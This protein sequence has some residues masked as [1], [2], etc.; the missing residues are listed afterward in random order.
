MLIGGRI[1]LGGTTP[2]RWALVLVVALLAVPSAFA[3]KV[4]DSFIGDEG[5]PA[6]G[7]GAD[8]GEFNVPRDVA[9]NSS[10]AGGVVAGTTY[11]VDSVNHRIQRHGPDG[12]FVSLWGKDVVEPGEENDSG[13]GFE[14]CDTTAGSPNTAEDCQA[15]EAGSLGG[16]LSLP[17]GIAV[18]QDTGA[19]YVTDRDNN[20]VQQYTATGAFVRA[21]GWDVVA[22]G[23]P[24]DPGS[25]STFQICQSAAAADCKAGVA[26]GGVGQIGPNTGLNT[27]RVEVTRDGT[28]ASG[29]VLVADGGN[30]NSPNRR[31]LKF[32]LDGTVAALPAIGSSAQ[33]GSRQ[34]NHIAVDGNTLY[35]ADGTDARVER[36]DLSTGSSLGPVPALPGGAPAGLEIDPVT[37]RLL[38]V[39]NP[40]QAGA[41]TVIYEI[42][43]AETGAPEIVDVHLTGSGDQAVNGLGVAHFGSTDRL[44]VSSNADPIGHRVLVLD[45]DGAGPIG[46]DILGPAEIGGHDAVLSGLVSPNG[47]TGFDTSYDFEY[48]KDGVSWVT[49]PGDP[50]TAP[51]GPGPELVSKLVDGLEANTFYRVR[52]LARREFAKDLELLSPELTFLT[53]KLPPTVAALAANRITDTEAQ[54]RARLNPE[55]SPTQWHFQYVDDMEYAESGWAN[56][57]SEPVPA[58]QAVGTTARNVAADVDGLQPDTIYHYRLVATNGQ[59]VDPVGAPGDLVVEGAERTFT[60]WAAVAAPEGRSYEMVTSPDKPS[61]RGGEGAPAFGIPD[62]FPI[63]GLPSSDG[64]RILWSA[65]LGTVATA[66]GGTAFPHSQPFEVFERLADRWDPEAVF[67]LPALDAGVDAV[68]TMDAS[69]ADLLTQTWRVESTQFPSGSSHATRILGDDGGYLGSGWYD[70]LAEIPIPKLEGEWLTG[71]DEAVVGENRSFMVRFASGNTYRGLL[72]D[73][74][75]SGVGYPNEVQSI[76][77]SGASGGSFRLTFDGQTTGTIALDASAM[78]VEGALEALSNLDPPDV[79]VT[80]GDDQPWLVIFEGSKRRVDVPEITA[81]ATGLVGPPERAVVVVTRRNGWPAAPADAPTQTT[82]VAPYVMGPPDW[83]PLDLVSECTAGTE[84]PMRDPEGTSLLSSFDPG[85]LADDTIGGQPCVE[86]EVVSRRGAAGGDGDR[87][88]V[89]AASGDGRRIFFSAPDQ[90]SAVIANNLGGSQLGMPDSNGSKRCAVLSGTDLDAGSDFVEHVGEQTECPPQV[91]VR[92]YDSQGEPTVRWLSR[93][94]I[95]DQNAD[96]LFRGAYFEGA[97]ADGRYVFFRTA[98]PLVGDDP[99]AGSD[100]VSGTAQEHSWDLYRYELPESLDDD[101]AGPAAGGLTRI[102]GG[103]SGGADPNTNSKGSAL[104]HVSQDGQRVYFVTRAP[105]GGGDADNSLP[106]DGATSPGGSVSQDSTRN[107][108]LYDADSDSYKFI[109][110]LPYADG[111]VEACASVNGLSAYLRNSIGALREVSCVRGTS[112]GDAVVFESRARLTVDDTDDASDVYLYDADID[113][114][115]RLSAPPEQEEPYPCAVLV[116]PGTH[117]TVPDPDVACN[118]DLGLHPAQWGADIGVG[119]LAG[120]SRL[121]LAEDS[122][123]GLRAVYFESRLGLLPADVNDGYFDTYEWRAGRLSLVSPGV[124]D[125]HAFYSGNGRDGDDVFFQTTQRISPWEVDAVDGDVYDARVGGGLPDPPPPP[126]VCD[127]LGGGCQGAGGGVSEPVSQPTLGTGGGD[128]EPGDRAVLSVAV[129]ARSRRAAARRRMLALTVRSNVAGRVTARARARV[130]TRRRAR[131]RLRQVAA[132]SGRVSGGGT[133]A[134]V[135]L[136]LNA[137]A[138]RQLR[139][140][141]RLTLSIVISMPGARPETID[142]ALSGRGRR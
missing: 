28:P 141:G 42:E 1:Q 112:S 126:A 67:S 69:S 111:T 16:E 50:L 131:P 136:R 26:G 78:V 97:S 94:E 20:R 135:R 115:V 101:P 79:R 55:G 66:D 90:N 91:F 61:R 58:A 41:D 49:V 46:L 9:V 114:L 108:Y 125:D 72:G 85:D 15:G 65:G 96:G 57:V 3:A 93:S 86:G 80:G 99:N 32:N 95:A 63:P 89:N 81:D 113:K 138:R 40:F 109:A 47:P 105:F 10:G 12:G 59:E 122:D 29:A 13:S 129:S 106:A 31:I 19:V 127:V 37:G 39:V 88:L 70:F 103:L 76:T 130:R 74:D 119:G 104:R 133:A 6:V 82:G 54:L 36:F 56:A 116:V 14:L 120:L 17:Q 38:A 98:Q 21:W 128:L 11:V 140:R 110:Q 48:S 53:D 123:G 30:P 45:A 5:P 7:E 107:L 51:D 43:N 73:S 142:V 23:S 68:V 2:F 35:A 4:G 132:G 118:G 24:S 27:P 117:I 33:F 137:P 100:V 87:A 34:P 25:V 22:D 62:A 83:Q 102:T 44:L 18:D 52:M 139:R 134:V 124:S 75:A 77:V 71:S 92:Q 8:G 121:N 64:Q 84:I 60:T